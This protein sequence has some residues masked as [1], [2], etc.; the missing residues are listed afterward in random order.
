MLM[1]FWIVV[2]ITS[3][4]LTFSTSAV[5]AQTDT[6]TIIQESKSAA[7]TIAIRK[8]YNPRKATLFSAALPGLGQIYTKQYWKLPILY[9]GVGVL[10]YFIIDNH[11]NYIIWR[12]RYITQRTA[13][14]SKLELPIVYPTTG[15]AIPLDRLKQAKDYYRRNRDFTVILSGLTYV[16]NI[17][18]A[19]VTAHLK[20][21]DLSDDLSLSVQPAV[22]QVAGLPVTG[23]SLTL[24]LK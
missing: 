23:V 3:F 18:D 6:T 1:K 15:T 20:D 12:D 21:F 11:R 10:G 8:R 7:K 24:H 17:V 16:L 13:S 14:E 19:N 4:F 22:D 5:V 2:C 9:A